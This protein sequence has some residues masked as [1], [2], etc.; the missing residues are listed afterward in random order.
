MQS[1]SARSGSYILESP[2]NILAG[3]PL[4]EFTALADTSGMIRIPGARRRYRKKP[5]SWLSALA[6]VPPSSRPAVSLTSDR[7]GLLTGQLGRWCSPSDFPKTRVSLRGASANPSVNFD[8]S[9]PYTLGQFK[10]WEDGNTA[11][12]IFFSFAALPSW[13]NSSCCH[14]KNMTLRHWHIDKKRASAIWRSDILLIILD[15]TRGTFVFRL[16]EWVLNQ[17]FCPPLSS[18]RSRPLACRRV[19]NHRGLFG[20]TR[21]C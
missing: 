20:Q 6:L 9:S 16:F 14:H 10:Q 19:I 17:I 4:W 7:T 1:G 2:E 15:A 18:Q 12:L 11:V 21:L 3:N 13:N 5:C 8:T